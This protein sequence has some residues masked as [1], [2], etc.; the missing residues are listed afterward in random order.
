[1]G[2]KHISLILA[3]LLIFSLF[4]GEEAFAR[5]RK[6][7]HRH[8]H[9]AAQK[10]VKPVAKPAPVLDKE[11]Q[12]YQTAQK[13]LTPRFYQAYRIVERIARANKIDEFSW[14]ILCLKNNEYLDDYSINAYADKANLI[15][16]TPGLTDTFS[17]E[18]SV[19]AY[20]IAHEM[21]HSV[22]RDQAKT[23]RSQEQ[24]NRELLDKINSSTF[25]NATSPK[26]FGLLDYYLLNS[27]YKNRVDQEKEEIEQKNK[28]LQLD[29]LEEERRMEYEADKNAIIYE[30]R[31]G[32]EPKASLR[33]LELFKREPFPTDVEVSGHPS[34][35]NRIWQVQ[36]LLKTL[37]IKA[38]KNEGTKNFS[39]SKPL[40]YETTIYRTTKYTDLRS[41]LIH[42]KYGSIDDVNQ[43]F[44]RLFGK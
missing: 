37:N 32:I 17:N 6:K 31:A 15:V 38:L 11:T 27:Y 42:S 2:K 26:G 41:L 10:V 24:I 9:K 3:I 19:L 22:N 7:H 28:D 12:L 44:R 30:T 34:N 36:N 4:N 39:S 29:L 21:A 14:R 23:S 1:M 13:E 40:T 8:A 18:V 5:K 43:P 20:V 33:V 25:S 35:E 16:L